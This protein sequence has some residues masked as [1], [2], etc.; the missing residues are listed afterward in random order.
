MIAELLT[1]QGVITEEALRRVAQ[2]LSE[3]G[4]RLD[5]RLVRLG[6]VSESD[7]VDALC[8]E[9]GLKRARPDELAPLPELGRELP[10]G[11]VVQRSVLPIRRDGDLVTVAVSDPFDLEVLDEL[12]LL[13]DCRTQAVL[14]GV[15]EIEQAIRQA[16]GV[17]AEAVDRMLAAGDNGGGI[18]VIRE[19]EDDPDDLLEMAEDASLIQFVNQL[20]IEALKDRASDVHIEP[21]EGSM[22]VRYRIDGVLQQTATPKQI[23]QFQAAIISRIKIMANLD[24]AE[25]RRPQDGRIQLRIAGREVDVRVSIIPGLH[26]EGVVLRLLD[27]EQASL[28]LGELGMPADT[29][30]RMER[31]VSLPHG[32]ILVTGPTGSGKTTTLYAALSTINSVDKKIV[33][34]ED[35]IEYQLAGILQIGVQPKINLS[36][37]NG[38]RSILRHDPDVIMIGEIRDAETAEIAIQASLTGHLVFSTL[39][40]NDAAGA[41]VRLLDVGAEPF[42]VASSLEAIMAQRLVRVI[43]EF[44]KEPRRDEAVDLFRD[45]TGRDAETLYHGA[46]CERCRGTGYHGRT[47][48]FE[49]IVLDEELREMILARASTGRFKKNALSKGM[50]TLRDDGWERVL[51]GVTTVDEVLRVTHAGGE[52]RAQQT[53]GAQKREAP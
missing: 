43:C 16:Y 52:N 3:D 14:A 29:R 15:G 49:L 41:V 19:E 53:T 34:V 46:G 37:A 28:G 1:R 24:I 25:K 12:A 48:L 51:Q 9:T 30:R 40:T 17:G 18:Q 13:L 36:F 23:K 10:V 50:R 38:L 35:P 44:C 45:A 8:R 11:F 42:L 33:T 7:L 4:E 31:L 6:L 32:I 2:G 47:G 5:R 22:R 26:G 20:L 27:R 39:H 21:G